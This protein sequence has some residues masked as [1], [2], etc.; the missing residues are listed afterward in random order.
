[1][2]Y[3]EKKTITTMLVALLIFIAYCIYAFGQWQSGAIGAND[4]VAWARVMLKFIG[5]NIILMIIVQIVFHVGMAVSVSVKEAVRQGGEVDSNE[6]DRTINAEIVEDEM[7]KLISLKSHTIGYVII[8]IG[9]VI[10]LI[11]LAVA[12]PA[13]VMI[14]TLFIAFS[15]STLAEGTVALVYYRKGISNG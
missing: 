12:M 13:A 6:L 14:N 10:G 8:G 5:A 15:L 4:L 11:T 1:M 2:S 7:D 9:F 3:G